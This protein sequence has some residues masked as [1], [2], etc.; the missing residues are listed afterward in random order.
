MNPLDCMLNL[1]SQFFHYEIN[2][3]YARGLK[4]VCFSLYLMTNN[5]I[6]ACARCFHTRLYLCVSVCLFVC[7]IPKIVALMDIAQLQI[8]GIL[9]K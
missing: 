3:S 7:I 2:G 6:F 8:D 1:R 9:V 5:R 4:I